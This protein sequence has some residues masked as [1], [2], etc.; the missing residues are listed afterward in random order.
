MVQYMQTIN[1]VDATQIQT[2]IENMPPLTPNQFIYGGR[3]DVFVERHHDS[4][5]GVRSQEWGF[6]ASLDP[7]YRWQAD[8]L[9]SQNNSVSCVFLQTVLATTPFVA[10]DTQVSAN[11][12][13]AK[14][15]VALKHNAAFPLHCNVV[16]SGASR[17]HHHPDDPH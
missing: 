12:G 16:P 10:M 9:Q 4:M 7:F 6:V 11:G 5:A 2:Y 1:Y 3:S 8:G 15:V 17:F 13:V 14:H